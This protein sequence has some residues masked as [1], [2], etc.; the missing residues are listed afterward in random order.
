MVLLATSF[1]LPARSL[2]RRVQRMH[3]VHTTKNEQP[4]SLEA[5]EHLLVVVFTVCYG[6]LGYE[7][8]SA[9]FAANAKRW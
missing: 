3:V 2:T 9:G 7:H 8:F 6:Y 5:H 1:R 4:Q